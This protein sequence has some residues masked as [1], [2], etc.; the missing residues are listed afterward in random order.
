MAYYNQKCSSKVY[1]TEEDKENTPK[2]LPVFSRLAN[3]TQRRLEHSD[4]LL[5]DDVVRIKTQI[6]ESVLHE[7]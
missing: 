4:V 7:K 2:R 5:A 3:D 6:K 1:K